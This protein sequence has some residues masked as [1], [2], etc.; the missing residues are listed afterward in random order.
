[1][2][3]ATQFWK[4]CFLWVTDFRFVL[5]LETKEG[6]VWEHRSQR[7][8]L[9]SGMFLLPLT[10]SF[11]PDEMQRWNSVPSQWASLTITKMKECQSKYP[12]PLFKVCFLLFLPEAL[13]LSLFSVPP[14]PLAPVS[15][16]SQLQREKHTK[17]LQGRT[18]YKRLGKP[19]ERWHTAMPQ[20]SKDSNDRSSHS[21]I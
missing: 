17:P 6:W 1:M 16:L 5:F 8:S 21:K 12:F 3:S 14:L 19:S 4:P 2:I 18:K 15:P 10:R 9:L 11:L 13:L 7:S 20:E